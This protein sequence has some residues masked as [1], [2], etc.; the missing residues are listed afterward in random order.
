MN[1]ENECLWECETVDIEMPIGILRIAGYRCPYCKEKS[2]FA[3]EYCPKCGEQ[4]NGKYK[5]KK[6]EN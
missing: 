4:L 1:E 3:T 6:E 5:P 2:I